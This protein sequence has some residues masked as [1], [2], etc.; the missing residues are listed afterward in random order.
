MCRVR[1]TIL[2]LE[3]K[4]LL[5]IEDVA[6]EENTKEELEADQAQKIKG[7]R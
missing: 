2:R 4:H 3:G 1:L 5:D 7:S 6:V